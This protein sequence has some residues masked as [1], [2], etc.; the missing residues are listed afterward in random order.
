VN[1]A[2]FGPYG[3]CGAKIKLASPKGAYRHRES[4]SADLVFEA[5]WRKEFV[6]TMHCETERRPT[7]NAYLHGNF[8]RIGSEMSVQMTRPRSCNPD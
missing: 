5:Q 8:C 1:D 7:E 6:R 4:G 3:G 2:D